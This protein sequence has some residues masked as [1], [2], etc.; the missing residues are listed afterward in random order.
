MHPRAWVVSKQE[1]ILKFSKRLLEI[2]D[3]STLHFSVNTRFQLIFIILIMIFI[4]K[5]SLFSNMLFVHCVIILEMIDDLRR[6]IF[7]NFIYKSLN[8]R[9]M[10]PSYHKSGF[11]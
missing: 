9:R 2:W 7:S 1:Q 3:A 10:L 8:L 4:I 6:F 5:Q 11:K